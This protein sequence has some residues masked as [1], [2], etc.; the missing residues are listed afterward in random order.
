L[1]SLAK[2]LEGRPFHLVATH[3]QNGK[4]EDVTAYI[5]SK[6]LPADAPNFTVTSFGGHPD[7]KGN[8][9]VPYYMVFD[10]HGRL[11]RHHMCGDYHGGD[12][13]EMIEWVDKL[14]LDAPEIYLGSEPFSVVDDLAEQVRK[15]KGL[16]RTVKKIQARLVEASGREQEEL[17]RL[18][19][20]V[21]TYRDGGME[22]A[23]GLMAATPSLV[24]PRLEGLEKEFAGSA[25]VVA[26][27]KRIEEIEGS[28]VLKR[29]LKVE[30]ELAKIEK[31]LARLKPCKVCK[32]KGMKA[33]RLDCAGCRGQGKGVLSGAAKKIEKLLEKNGD[34]PIAARAKEILGRVG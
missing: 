8:G 2:R 22:R 31:S 11:A 9:Y 28:D 23:N 1:V 12:G 5:A 24:L 25:L 13:L 18:C 6:G 10:H 26:V 27:T 7:V 34:L 32:R 29:S 3:C 4:K 30:K 15:K 16:G 21:K 33:A 20:A 17:Q 14:L 19:A